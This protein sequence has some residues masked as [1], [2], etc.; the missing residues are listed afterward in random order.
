MNVSVLAKLLHGIKLTFVS[1]YEKLG[2]DSKGLTWVRLQDLLK[3]ARKQRVTRQLNLLDCRSNCHVV[4]TAT[5]PGCL[6]V[7]LQQKARLI[8]RTLRDILQK[9]SLY[10]SQQQ[11]ISSVSGS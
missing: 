7:A 10:L 2:L 1:W 9:K 3:A 5:A 4:K 8:Q 11:G 6:L